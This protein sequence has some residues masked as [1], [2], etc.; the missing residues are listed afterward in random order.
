M[1]TS[2]WHCVTCLAL[3]FPL[4]RFLSMEAEC[5]CSLIQTPVMA[6]VQLITSW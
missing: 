3:V 5:Y 4:F 6:V 2:Q 1:F